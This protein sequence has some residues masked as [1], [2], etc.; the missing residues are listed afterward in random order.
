MKNKKLYRFESC[1]G[2]IIKNDFDVLRETKGF[3][4]IL[5]AEDV[6]KKVSKTAG[7]Q[8]YACEDEM[9]AMKQFYFRK[10]KQVDLLEKFLA[11]AIE[12]KQRS[13][14]AL[15]NKNVDVPFKVAP[16]I[17]YTEDFNY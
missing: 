12:H 3:F 11:S 15:K 7:K 13:F 5:L 14:E 16:R 17:R 9:E 8:N 4:I 1:L 6:E 10:R 2:A